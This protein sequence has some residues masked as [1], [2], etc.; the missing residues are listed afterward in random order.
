MGGMNLPCL[1]HKI[2]TWMKMAKLKMKRIF[3]T[4]CCSIFLQGYKW[5]SELKVRAEKKK[6]EHLEVKFGMK[7]SSLDTVEYICGRHWKSQREDRQVGYD[8]RSKKFSGC[9]GEVTQAA[10]CKV[11]LGKIPVHLG[12]TP[13]RPMLHQTSFIWAWSRKT[14][15]LYRHL[16]TSYPG[17]PWFWKLW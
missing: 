2:S 5:G 17:P 15:C 11:F 10:M 3:A 14:C 1:G 12:I 16:N 7:Q 8:K 4:C 13:E 6:K 9:C